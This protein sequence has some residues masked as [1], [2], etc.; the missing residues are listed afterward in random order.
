MSEQETQPEETQDVT[1]DTTDADATDAREADDEDESDWRKNFDADKA[2]DRIRKLQS[3]AKNLRE[4]A[5]QAETKAGDV[6]TL[7]KTNGDLS[8]E[9]L[10]LKVG[11]KLGLP[12]ALAERLRGNTEE[13]LIADADEL[14]KIAGGRPTQRKPVEALRGGGAPEQ[15][16]EETDVRKLGERM[17]SH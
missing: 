12:M 6:D 13:E 2:A 4:R 17:F 7:T 8:A 15:E 11:Y 5:K 3:E 9:N 14:V 16:A 10:R 1:E